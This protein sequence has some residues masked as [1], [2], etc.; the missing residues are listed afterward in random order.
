MPSPDPTEPALDALRTWSSPWPLSM[1]RVLGPLQRGSTD[2]CHWTDG[3][4]VVWRT[5][6]TADGPTV[7]KLEQTGEATV[8]CAAWGSGADA[9]VAALPDLLGARD[10][11]ESFDP[12]GH[13][14]LARLHGAHPWLRM[15]RSGRMFEA[16]VN[17]VF[18]QRVTVGEALAGRRWLLRMYGER[19]SF[20]PA[21]MPAH[22]RVHPGPEQWRAIPSWDWHRAGVDVYRAATINR[23]ADVAGRIDEISDMDRFEGVLRLRAV[24]GVGVWTAAEARQRALGDA[25]AISYGDTHLA[26]FVGHALMGEGVDDHGMEELLARWPGHRHRVVR[27]LMLGVGMG[28]VRTSPR[29][30]KPQPRRHL[31]F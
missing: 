29:I 6:R 20:E 14:L 3:T 15:P 4:S 16:V 9:F 5:S 19:P 27:L 23:C 22:M 8:R 26:R 18:E 21:G 1:V 7:A 12:D 30:R 13:D 25:D 31:R 28:V 17:A 2:P 10:E 24:R 11:P